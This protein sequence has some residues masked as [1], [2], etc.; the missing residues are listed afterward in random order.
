MGMWVLDK[1]RTG[2]LAVRLVHG[3]KNLDRYRSR[4]NITLTGAFLARRPM[5]ATCTAITRRRKVGVTLNENDSKAVDND[6]RLVGA[7]ELFGECHGRSDITQE[8]I[9][10]RH[11]NSDLQSTVVLQYSTCTGCLLLP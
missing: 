3:F 11:T 10:G 4:M 9:P 7:L 1:G 6:F 5:A 8:G 2:D